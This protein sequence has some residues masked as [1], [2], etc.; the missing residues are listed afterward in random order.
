MLAKNYSTIDQIPRTAIP[1][2]DRQ[3]KSTLDMYRTAKFSNSTAERPHTS[4][5]LV[6]RLNTASKR[7]VRFADQSE[8]DSAEHDLERAFKPD[9]TSYLHKKFRNFLIR[10]H[11]PN[12]PKPNFLTL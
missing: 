4:F 5:L 6:H 2:F 8:I 10:R 3:N 7:K 12:L 11:E 1:G 9:L